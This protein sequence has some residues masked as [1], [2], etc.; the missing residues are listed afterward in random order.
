MATLPANPSIEQLRHQAEDLLRAAQRGDAEA[1]AQLEVVSDRPSLAGAQL[2][3]GD[4]ARRSCSRC[5][6][7]KKRF[8]RWIFSIILRPP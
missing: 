6:R 1:L 3:T 8:F 4:R 5:P 7:R 2:A